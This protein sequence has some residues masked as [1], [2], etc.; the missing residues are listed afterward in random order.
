MIIFIG[1]LFLLASG[2]LVIWLLRRMNRC[3]ICGGER[4]KCKCEML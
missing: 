2:G 3:E 1:I 4:G